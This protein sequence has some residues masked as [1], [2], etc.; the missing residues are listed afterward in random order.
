M[1][2]S[3]LMNAY[4]VLV[5]KIAIIIEKNSLPLISSGK[6]VIKT[7]F[8]IP[9]GLLSF[10]NIKDFDYDYYS[11][12]YS[13]F[14][15]WEIY[16]HCYIPSGYNLLNP[17]TCY[18]VIGNGSIIYNNV[19]YSKNSYFV[20]SNVNDYSINTGD[21]IVIPALYLKH[22]ISS[23]S[24][25]LSSLMIESP[26]IVGSP[27]SNY[28]LVSGIKIYINNTSNDDEIIVFPIHDED[29]DIKNFDGFS[30]IRDKLLPSLDHSI[31]TY[32]YR[33][34]FSYNLLRSEFDY[35]R[36]NFVPEFTLFNK[37]VPYACKWGYLDGFDVRNN[38][39][40]LNNSVC[41]G[42]D[43]FAPSHVVE[44]QSA[45]NITHEWYYLVSDL[46]ISNEVINSSDYCY[47]RD[48]FNIDEINTHP[49]G[50]VKKF[51][52]VPT[53]NGIEVNKHQYRYSNIK[54][55][56]YN[57][58]CETFFR[59]VR[60]VFKEISNLTNNDPNKLYVYGSDNK[61]VFLTNNRKYDG[62]KFTVVLNPVKESFELL[63]QFEQ[64]QQMMKMMNKNLLFM[65]LHYM[66]VILVKLN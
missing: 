2:K 39:Y 19:I 44:S 54:Y 32:D 28:I 65:L 48:G 18:I 31:P 6:F 49:D 64:M 25:S 51:T 47:I 20:T 11:S 61:P 5:N 40:R 26:I 34:K 56:K 13:S 7:T 59:G 57:G 58:L 30:A 46:D 63:K 24:Q 14:P 50:F 43:N 55:N 62:Y 33:D 4:N 10:Y 45:S 15:F 53:V 8:N 29:V 3:D 38:P 16:Q 35:N 37:L 66:L 60:V 17:D 27:E 9:F 36:E 12:N 41:F 23:P 22:G 1:N 42:T 21:V 52:H